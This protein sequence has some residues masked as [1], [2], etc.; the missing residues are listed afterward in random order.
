MLRIGR[1][2]A[3]SRAAKHLTFAD[4][5]RMALRMNPQRIVIGEVRGKEA[6]AV[7]ASSR[8]GYPVLTTLHGESARHGLQNL[9]AMAL[10]ARETQARLD[11]SAASFQRF[12]GASSKQSLFDLHGC[13]IALK[14]GN[15]ERPSHS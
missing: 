4:L 5:V 1:P 2:A 7:L 15:R 8:N 14:H 11:V 10:E 6:Y 13:K 12:L 3:C 9:I